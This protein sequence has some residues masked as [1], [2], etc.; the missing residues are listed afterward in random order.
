MSKSCKSF[1]Y[2]NFISHFNKYLINF[3]HLLWDYIMDLVHI[4]LIDMIIIIN[5]PLVWVWIIFCLSVLALHYIGDLS[6]VHPSSRP[7]VAQICCSPTTTLTRGNGRGWMDVWIFI[8]LTTDCTW[9]SK[10]TELLF[11]PWFYLGQ[12]G[13]LLDDH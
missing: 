2:R 3:L 5:S 6:R 1:N 4:A 7:M 11:F 9:E 10:I 8:H 13:N 12:V